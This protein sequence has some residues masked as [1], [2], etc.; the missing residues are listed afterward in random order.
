MITEVF[1]NFI[2]QLKILDWSLNWLNVFE[3]AFIAIVIFFFYKKFIRNTQSEKLVRGIVILFIAWAFSEF[4]M[5]VDLKIIGVFI[6]TLVMFV[7]L[8]LIV[9]FQPELRR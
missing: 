5:R 6:K 3:F 2:N 8:S 9:I 4:L 1:T 7:S